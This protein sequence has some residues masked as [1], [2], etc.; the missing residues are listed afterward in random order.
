[1]YKLAVNP[2]SFFLLAKREI[3][4]L[5]IKQCGLQT[6]RPP[7]L[8]AFSAL[9]KD[10]PDFPSIQ[11]NVSLVEGF[12]SRNKESV[13]ELFVSLMSKLLSVEGLWEQGLCASNF[14]GSW[15]FKTWERG[16]GNLSVSFSM[17]SLCF[18]SNF[19]KSLFIYTQQA[20]HAG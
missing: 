8:P 6:R 2:K 1:M 9:L 19:C 12:G 3:N 13:A 16:V 11:R 10:G 17:N 20:I 4:T 15:I 5:F 18:F 7:I 14:E